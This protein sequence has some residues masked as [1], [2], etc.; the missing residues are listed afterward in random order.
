MF[1]NKS[2]LMDYLHAH[3]QGLLSP[4]ALELNHNT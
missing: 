1:R 4:A 3:P 2:V